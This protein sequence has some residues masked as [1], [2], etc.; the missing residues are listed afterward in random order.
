MKSATK[1]DGFSLIEL[2]VVVILIGILAAIA[3]PSLLKSQQAAR[4]AQASGNMR[5]INSSEQTYFATV[6]IQS[7]YGSYAELT[8]GGFLD[9][10]FTDGATKGVHTYA[11]ISL[12]TDDNGFCATAT[13]TDAASKSFATSHRGNVWYLTGVT[14]PA[15]DADTGLSAD[16]I[17][18]GN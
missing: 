8:G 2:L 3:I 6:G 16:G 12:G 7:D 1:Q 11:A 15:C 18:I 5:S 9:S 14:A 4:E 10:T 17:E 13:Q